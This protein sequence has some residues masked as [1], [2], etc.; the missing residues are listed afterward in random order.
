M[1]Y[2]AGSDM[3]AEGAHRTYRYEIDGSDC[4]TFVC[5]NWLRFATDNAT[6]ELSEAAVIGYPIWQYISDMDCRQL[7]RDLFSHVRQTGITATYPFRCDSPTVRR[8]MEMRLSQLANDHLQFRATLVREEPQPYCP[9]LD[10][11][12]KRSDRWIT[13]CAWCKK[14]KMPE[15]QWV[16]ILDSLRVLA[17]FGEPEFPNLTHGICPPCKDAFLNRKMQT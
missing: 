17:P 16:D 10:S 8:S 9:L 3:S 11:E 13:M 4:I 7:F 12:V 6:P 1:I 15:G 5:P 2:M 14:V